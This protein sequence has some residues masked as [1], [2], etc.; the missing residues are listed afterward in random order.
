MRRM[1]WVEDDGY[2]IQ[3]PRDNRKSNLSSWVGLVCVLFLGAVLAFVLYPCLQEIAS[4]KWP[5]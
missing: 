2:G 4:I 5:W 1:E 3:D